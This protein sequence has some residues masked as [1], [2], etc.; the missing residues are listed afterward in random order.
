M[1]EIRD[2]YAEI[3]GKVIP[4]GLNLIVPNEGV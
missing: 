4:C 1:L 2:L 3:D